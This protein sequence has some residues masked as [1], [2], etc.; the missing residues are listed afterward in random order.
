MTLPFTATSSTVRAVSVP[1]LVI[2]VCAAVVTVAAV[3]EVL[4]VTLPVRSPVT[5]PSTS[6]TIVPAV[7]ETTSELKDA[8]GI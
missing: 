5:S 4:P 6:A 7:P 1:R 3:P 2:F 8:S